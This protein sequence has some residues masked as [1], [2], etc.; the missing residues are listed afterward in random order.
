MTSKAQYHNLEI[1]ITDFKR[2]S[3]T[4]TLK[5]TNISGEDLCHCEVKIEGRLEPETDVTDSSTKNRNKSATEVSS[6]KV[7]AQVDLSSE[8]AGSGRKV[9][10]K[11]HTEESLTVTSVNEQE[12]KASST[13]LEE[14]K[15]SATSSVSIE[16]KSSASLTAE[17]ERLEETEEQGTAMVQRKKKS[18]KSTIERYVLFSSPT[19]CDNN[20]DCHF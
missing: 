11:E 14:S 7:E 20:K 19:A 2:D 16:E 8:N 12:I 17:V 18:S 9:A 10:S 3:G 1:P 13:A 15:L 6:K 5:A 4:Y